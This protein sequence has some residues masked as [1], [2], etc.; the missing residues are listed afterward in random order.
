MHLHVV[1]TF[2]KLLWVFCLLCFYS[3]GKQLLNRW[4]SLTNNACKCLCSNN[5]V[6]VDIYFIFT[7]YREWPWELCI[8]IIQYTIHNK[9]SMKWSS[10]KY[11][12]SM[13]E[14]EKKNILFLTYIKIEHCI[15]A[16]NNVVS[17]SPCA[18]YDYKV[19]MICT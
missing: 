13:F 17:I 3:C 18:T 5:R 4:V 7:V 12:L 1:Q 8:I 11:E 19:C 9:Q 16:R 14:I 15:D 6:P 2:D 10:W